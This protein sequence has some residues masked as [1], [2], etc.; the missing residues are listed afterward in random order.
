MQECDNREG[1]W[2]MADT[3]RCATTTDD[4]SKVPFFRDVWT[5]ERKISFLNVPSKRQKAASRTAETETKWA[6]ASDADQALI[7]C[8]RLGEGSLGPLLEYSSF[9]VST[10]HLAKVDVRISFR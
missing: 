10:S 7:L 5:P 9:T 3:C 8:A 1:G 4:T 6:R 2:K